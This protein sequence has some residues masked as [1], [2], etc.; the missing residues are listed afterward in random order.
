MSRTRMLVSAFTVAVAAGCD[1]TPA[2]RP[3]PAR[4][5]AEAP[6]SRGNPDVRTGT[7]RP[8]PKRLSYDPTTFTL[9][10][11]DVPGVPA[12]WMV[13]TGGQRAGVPIPQTHRFAAPVKAQTV[14]VFY[15][16]PNGGTSDP[17][18]L[19]DIL[20]AHTAPAIQ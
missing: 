14:S 16:V 17:V 8:D 11:Y 2:D 10:V 1:S 20:E 6:P 7:P 12:Q 19:Q 13:R 5:A 4:P 9:T 18:T 15:A 3:E